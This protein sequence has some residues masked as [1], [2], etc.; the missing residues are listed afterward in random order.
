ARTKPWL[1]AFYAGTM[2]SLAVSGML[3]E[4]GPLYF[5]GLAMATF[6]LTWQV[7][8]L[9]PDLPGNCLIRFRANHPFGLVIFFAIALG[10]AV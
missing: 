2:I 4:L 7:R 8:T 6:M 5:M 3:A 10:H 1:Y 9:R